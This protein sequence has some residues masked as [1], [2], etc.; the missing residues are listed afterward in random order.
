MTTDIDRLH[1][2]VEG[3]VD[4]RGCGKTFARCHEVAGYVELGHRNIFCLV[5]SIRDR[6]YIVPMLAGVLYDHNLLLG[7]SSPR[8]VF[9]AGNSVIRFITEERDTRGYEG[10][11]V[12]MRHED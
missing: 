10:I 2:V 3:K 9:T 7:A 6:E 1:R 8:D 11:M 4:H 12:L 5:S